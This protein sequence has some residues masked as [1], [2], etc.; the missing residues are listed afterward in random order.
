MK[1]IRKVTTYIRRNREFYIVKDENGYWGIE[2][3]WFDEN[4]MLTKVF[5]GINGHLTKSAEQTI[6]EVEKTI[7][8]DYIA[9]STGCTKMEAIEKYFMTQFAK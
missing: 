7:E 3:K 4:G 8:I 1:T 5:N 6:K 9:E 2:S